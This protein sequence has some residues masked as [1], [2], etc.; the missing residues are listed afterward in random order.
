[1]TGDELIKLIGYPEKR[2]INGKEVFCYS[3]E[4]RHKIESD[5]KKCKVLARCTPEHKFAFIA[6]L[7][8]T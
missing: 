1:M 8:T 6:A 2:V 4:M 7:N 3:D 5:V